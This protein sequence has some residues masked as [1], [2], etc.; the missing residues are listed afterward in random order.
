MPKAE[1][2]TTIEQKYLDGKILEEKLD[3]LLGKGKW[4]VDV[5]RTCLF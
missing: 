2:E 1:M 3:D 4:E 5:S